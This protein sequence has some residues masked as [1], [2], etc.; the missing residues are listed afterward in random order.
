MSYCV[1]HLNK[2]LHNHREVVKMEF[3]YNEELV[4]LVKNIKGA[5]WSYFY[6]AWYVEKRAGL[7][8]EVLHCFKGRAYLDYKNL[9]NEALLSSSPE[10]TETL[11]PL[12]TKPVTERFYKKEKPKVKQ[13]ALFL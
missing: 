13:Y 7:L 2:M 11:K 3:P 8:Q 9:K 4:K 6:R 12:Y 1:V 5:R 10:T